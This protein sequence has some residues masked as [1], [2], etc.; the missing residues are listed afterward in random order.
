MLHRF[1]SKVL[2]LAVGLALTSTPYLEAQTA[3]DPELMEW[4]VP[5]EGTRPRDPFVAPDGKVWFVGQAGHYAAFLDRDTG[6]FTRFDLVDR[7]GPHNLVV[8]ADGIVWYTGNASRHIGRLDPATGE[9]QQYPMPTEASRDPH[10]LVLTDEGD[11]WFTVQGGNSIGKFWTATGDMR[12]VEAPEPPSTGRGRGSRPY[13]I[14]LDSHQAP[15]IALFGT[16]LIARVDPETFELT[17]FALPNERSRPRRLVIDSNDIIWYVDYALG[18]LGRLDPE[19]GDVTEWDNPGGEKSRPY[20]VAID[21]DDRVWFVETGPDPNTFVG[22]DTRIE[23]FIS[24][25]P[26]ESG[27]GAVRHMYYEESSNSIW[28]GTDTGTIGRAKLPPPRPRVVSDSELE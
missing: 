2:F 26:I 20:G 22:F 13:G 12:L 5:W 25:V 6:E 19:T 11:L 4:T 17:T 14:E 28:F 21:S 23:D 1:P 9:I 10:T 7:T 16:N 15:W 18:R 27:G 24:V 3:E 8:A